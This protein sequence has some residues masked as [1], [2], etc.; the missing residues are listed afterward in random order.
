[1]LWLREQVRADG[2][3]NHSAFS[4][5][6][7]YTLQILHGGPAEWLQLDEEEEEELEEAVLA[8]VRRG[9]RH[10]K[11]GSKNNYEQTFCKIHNYANLCCTHCQFKMWILVCLIVHS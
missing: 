6:S 3:A 5:H 7:H 2:A 1:M 8:Q 11:L 10:R 9:K 4:Q